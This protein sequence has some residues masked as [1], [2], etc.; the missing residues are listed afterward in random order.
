[1]V[2]S[3]SGTNH[4]EYSSFCVKPNQIENHSAWHGSLTLADAV[5]AVTGH[6]PFTFILSRL[7]AENGYL[8]TYVNLDRITHHVFF[9]REEQED[10]W[11]YSNGNEHEFATLD[12]MIKSAMHCDGVPQPLGR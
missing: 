7:S 11:C 6:P 3:I 8:L 10:K 9:S 5:M 4:S 12:E 2:Q 1:M